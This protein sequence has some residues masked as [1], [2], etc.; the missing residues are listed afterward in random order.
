MLMLKDR[1][2][3]VLIESEQYRALESVAAER[4]VSVAAVV[5]EAVGRYLASGPEQT[6]RAAQQ[7]LDAEP[8]PVGSPGELREELEELR[9]RR[10]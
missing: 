2:L 3:Q 7:I 1:R 6:A 8:M 4:G 9:G 10:G 5:R